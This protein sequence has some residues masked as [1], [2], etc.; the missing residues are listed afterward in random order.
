MLLQLFNEVRAEFCVI[1]LVVVQLLDFFQL[2]IAS[3][4]TAF[5]VS[6]CALDWWQSLFK[7]RNAL[8]T[9]LLYDVIAILWFKRLG[10]LTVFKFERHLF[11]S[12]NHS[13]HAEPRQFATMTGRTLVFAVLLSHFLEV[14][15]VLH[16]IVNFFDSCFSHSLGRVVEVAGHKHDVLYFHLTWVL[17]LAVHTNQVI[18]EVGAE[19]LANLTVWSGVSHHFPTVRVNARCGVAVVASIVCNCRVDR[20]LLCE[21]APVFTLD[22]TCA[23]AVEACKNLF[24]FL[25][26]LAERKHDVVEVHIGL[27]SL[28]CFFFKTHIHSGVFEEILN[29]A[30]LV[31][32]VL[33]QERFESVNSFSFGVSH[34]LLVGNKA[35]NILVES[36]FLNLLLVV[37]LV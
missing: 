24:V 34:F 10:N 15:T 35:V 36:F 14:G 7:W 8:V 19:W 13:V 33:S 22:H 17:T 37:L 30:F 20:E 23:N 26:V 31:A 11:K 12:R 4:L 5:V 18:T 27:H 6:D 1:V 3:H 29:H 25:S 9:K 21:F 32:V 16:W 28:V 2:L